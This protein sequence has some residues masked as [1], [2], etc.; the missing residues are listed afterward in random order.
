MSARLILE[1]V[2]SAFQ[3]AFDWDQTIRPQCILWNQKLYCG[4]LVNSDGS[5]TYR[6]VTFIVRP[7]GKAG[8]LE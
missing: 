1:S 6:E 4:S 5:V 7:Y 3:H 2:D 8:G